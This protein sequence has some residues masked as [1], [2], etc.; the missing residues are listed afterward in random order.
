M[1]PTLYYDSPDPMLLVMK[2]IEMLRFVLNIFR[3]Y[4]GFSIQILFLS[5]NLLLHQGHRHFCRLIQYE[6][7]FLSRTLILKISQDWS[8]MEVLIEEPKASYYLITIR[9][10][11]VLRMMLYP[12]I[13][14]FLRFDEFKTFISFSIVTNF[15]HKSCKEKPFIIAYL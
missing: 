14:L 5:S 9:M 10:N 6:W 2:M 1:K 11:K 4:S 15:P 8:I 7:Y 12:W 3:I 13:S